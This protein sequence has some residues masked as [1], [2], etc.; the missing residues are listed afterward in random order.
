ML[1]MMPATT[2]TADTVNM[3]FARNLPTPLVLVLHA[4]MSENVP[5]TLKSSVKH[6]PEITIKDL[7][8]VAESLPHN[9]G[10]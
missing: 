6:M 10:T 4:A 2:P 3:D 5:V 8:P 7:R 9:C 1:M